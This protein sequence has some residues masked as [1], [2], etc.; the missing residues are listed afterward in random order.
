MNLS[1]KL[2]N[3]I[4]HDWFSDAVGA[5]L[6]S[7][8]ITKEMRDSAQPFVDQTAVSLIPKAGVKPLV[9]PVAALPQAT[10]YKFTSNMDPK[11]VVAAI[12][13]L[14]VVMYY[15]KKGGK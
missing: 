2:Q 14:V 7:V 3:Q 9:S 6:N 8:G 1:E 11:I 15:L 10:G 13:A 5:G 4:K 12:V